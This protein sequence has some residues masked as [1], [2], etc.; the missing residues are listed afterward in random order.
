MGFKD[1]MLFLLLW[2]YV[3]FDVCV[4]GFGLRDMG[5]SRG[6]IC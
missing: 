5:L 3:C 4:I 1:G 2:M 6:F